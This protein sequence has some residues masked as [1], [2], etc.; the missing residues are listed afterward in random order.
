MRSNA[1]HGVLHVLDAGHWPQ[2]D[3]PADVAR[4]LLAGQTFSTIIQD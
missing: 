1:R 3:A 2:I 4:I